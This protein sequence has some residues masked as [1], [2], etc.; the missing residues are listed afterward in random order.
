MRRRRKSPSYLQADCISDQT[1]IDKSIFVMAS[2]GII[3]D[4][5]QMAV[6][7]GPGLR[8][9]V[10][11]KGCPLRCRWCH[12]PEGLS[13]RPQLMVSDNGCLHCGRCKEVCPSPENCRACGACIRV[14]PLHLRRIAG[15][16]WT[17]QDLAR[18]LQ[19]DAVILRM[20]RGGI[21]F[22]GGEPTMQGEFLLEVLSLLPDMHKAI[23]TCGFCAPDLFAKILEQLDYVLMDIKLADPVLHKKWTGQSN[24]LILQ[25]LEL[26]KASQKPFTIR[27]PLIPGVSDTPDNLSATADLLAGCSA[28]EK[29]ELLPYHK[30]A[31]AKYTMVGRAFDP[32]FDPDRQ[33]NADPS[34]FER[35]GIPVHVL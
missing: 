33:V 30:T 6:F 21:T 12:N 23:E 25:N 26:V 20:N 8:T 35:R 1:F 32:G 19:K 31:G 5:K 28:L 15:T 3:F 2:K 13:T 18:H 16:A 34:A 11:M 17:A 27:I 7:D 24:E 29:V 14:C 9:T 10:F 22:S 4:I